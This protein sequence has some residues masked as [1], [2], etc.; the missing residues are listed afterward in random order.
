[1]LN[2]WYSRSRNHQRPLKFLL[3]GIWNSIF[4]YGMFYLL[5][6]LFSQVFTTRYMAYMSALTFAQLL[7]I[8]NAYIF[9]K[10]ITFESNAKDWHMIW[11][12]IRFS[13][14]SAFAFCLN[15]LLLPV[16]VEVFHVVPKIAA[17]FLVLVV[18]L[19]SW[20]GHSRF[21]FNQGGK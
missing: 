3:V 14:T 10:I 16:L 11:E 5:D 8:I 13:L 2:P 19:V 20:I 1:M 12:F 6:T 9:H 7:G 4:G 21:S 15:L 17:L 18:V